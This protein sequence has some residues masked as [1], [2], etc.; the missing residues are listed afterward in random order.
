MEGQSICPQ[1]ERVTNVSSCNQINMPLSLKQRRYITMIVQTSVW[2]D[3]ND[4]TNL[5]GGMQHQSKNGSRTM[6]I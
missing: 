1:I 2:V 5:S 6:L 4:S 3:Y